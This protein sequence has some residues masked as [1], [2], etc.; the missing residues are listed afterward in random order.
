MNHMTVKT[1]KKFND[2]FKINTFYSSVN[3]GK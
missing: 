2:H 3:P 1:F